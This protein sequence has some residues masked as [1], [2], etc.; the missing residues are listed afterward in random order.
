MGNAGKQPSGRRATGPEAESFCTKMD[1]EAGE[2]GET[3]KY[4]RNVFK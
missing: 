3:V 1:G 4:T 2:T